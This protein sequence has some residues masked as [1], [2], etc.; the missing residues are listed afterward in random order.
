MAVQEIFLKEA[1]DIRAFLFEATGMI[2][3]YLQLS[4]GPA[5]LRY[6]QV[7][8]D[9][10]LILWARTKA[11]ARWQ[12]DMS[13]DGL[14]FGL[15]VDS[16]ARCIVRGE[17]IDGSYAQ[18]WLPGHEMEYIMHGPSL[19]LEIGVSP[20]L[21]EQMDWQLSGEPLQ[22]F[23]KAKID[24][25]TRTCQLATKAL[26]RTPA[27]RSG[28]VKSQWRETILDELDGLL[29]PW[30]NGGASRQLGRRANFD[31][32]KRADSIV[33]ALPDGEAFS[34]DL[35]AGELSVPR[36]TLFH[37]YRTVLGVGPR[38]Y[39]ELKRLEKLRARLKA[40]STR[41]LSVTR[42][43]HDLG[44]EDVGRLAGLYRRHYGENPRQTLAKRY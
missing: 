42:A 24:Q 36:R 6:R 23:S 15:L 12:D 5:N 1:D 41:N 31:L 16:K 22:R 34:V 19:T 8:L 30:L 43:A 14:H 44:F 25:L 9:G 2:P 27:A 40:G 20:H 29:N 32:V 17:E 11:R 33:D 28:S 7:D 35:V 38:R 4:A 39:V 26:Q 18:V 13:T 10:L 21:V 3:G 37:A